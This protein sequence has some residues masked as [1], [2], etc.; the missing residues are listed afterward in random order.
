MK[1]I[2]FVRNLNTEDQAEKLRSALEDTRLVFSVKPKDHIVVV[3]GDADAVYTA[4]VTI[5][6]CGFVIE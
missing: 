2:L 5:R 1:V 3:E 6:E 4:K